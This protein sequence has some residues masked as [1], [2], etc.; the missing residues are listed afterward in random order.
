MELFT[1]CRNNTFH[2]VS[3]RYRRVVDACL[4][5][6]DVLCAPEEPLIVCVFDVLCAPEEPLIVCVFDVL[7]APEEPLIVCVFDV[8]CAP[9]E[10]LIFLAYSRVGYHSGVDD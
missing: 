4:C 9:E 1:W 6:F 10:P 2:V 7:C 5:V 3:Q 8:L